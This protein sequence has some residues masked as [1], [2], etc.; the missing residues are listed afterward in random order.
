MLR[1]ND[2]EE[3]QDFETQ[4]VTFLSGISDKQNEWVFH[5]PW[6]TMESPRSIMFPHP[7]TQNHRTHHSA[8]STPGIR[9]S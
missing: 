7:T 4:A 3:R 8:L 2:D 5:R 9:K 6:K 1:C